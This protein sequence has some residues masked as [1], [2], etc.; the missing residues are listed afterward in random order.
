MLSLFR[1]TCNRKNRN[2]ARPFPCKAKVETT[3]VIQLRRTGHQA[4]TTRWKDSDKVERRSMIQTEL[5]RTEE[6]TRSSK[7]VQLGSQGNWTKWN[8]PE[9]KITWQELWNYEPLQLSFLLRSVYDMLP[10][11]TNLKLWK[12]TEDPT[13]PLCENIGS[14]RHIMSSCPTALSQGR[15]TWRHDQVLRV[16]PDILEKERKKEIDP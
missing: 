9:R 6:N 1:C 8:L 12:L 7:A 4:P 15:Y 5:R 10:S 14:L 13:C 3:D 11:P 16:M 2:I